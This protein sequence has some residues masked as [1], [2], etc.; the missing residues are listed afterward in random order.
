VSP[1]DS[2]ACFF[3]VAGNPE[4]YTGGY[5][6]DALIVAGLRE[7]GSTVAVNGLPGRFPVADDT[8]R[9]ALDACLS[10]Q[11]PG[12][13]VVIDGL[14]LG[15]LPEVVLAHASRLTIT[16][17]VHHPLADET[18]LDPVTRKMLFDSECAA[19]ASVHRIITTSRFT[20]RRLADFGVAA[21]RIHVVEP[22]VA[23]GPLAAA[24]RTNPQLLCVAT[25]VPRKGHITL[26]EALTR[27]RDHAWSCNLV[28]SLSRDPAHANAVREA[29]ETARL[30]DRV[31]LFGER[32][33]TQLRDHY[34]DADLFVL[35]SHYEGY[36]MVITEAIA[37]GLPVITTTGG[38]LADTLP[39]G[40]GIAVAPGDIDAL[41]AALRAFFED[42]RLRQALRTGARRARNHLKDWPQA[43]SLFAQAL[44]TPIPTSSSKP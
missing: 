29:I 10:A 8:A 4:Q 2:K 35:P 23:K 3:V 12:T 17:L 7:L 20:A 43:S 1:F 42:H 5:R 26:I 28:G 34:I 21:E 32:T 24:E 38:A 39:A 15:G 33:P 25:L 16:A 18:G 40:A 6:Y 31:R 11:A 14:A 36:G 30:Q 44:S 19:L 41:T 27:L 37:H 13:Q 22:G 9:H